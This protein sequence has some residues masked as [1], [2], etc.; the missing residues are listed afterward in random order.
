MSRL[1]FWTLNVVGG[2]CALLILGDMLLIRWNE[3]LRQSL[4][5][6]ENQLNRAQQIQ[7][8]AQNLVVR[9]AQSAQTEGALRQLL[10]RYEFKVNLSEP[11]KMPA[12]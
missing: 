3:K 7:T 6:T 10:A 5:V 12:P 11:G 1:Q 2:L 4:V 9:V 8:T